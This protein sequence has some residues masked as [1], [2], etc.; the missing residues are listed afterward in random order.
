MARSRKTPRRPG[1]DD[2]RYWQMRETLRRQ[3]RP[4]GV[5]GYPI[6]QQ[7]KWPHPL[8]W[9]CDHIVPRSQLQPND[10]R[11]WH[12]SNARPA[13]LRCNTARGAKPIPGTSGGLNPSGAW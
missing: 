2:K 12:I 8:S 7:L 13:H 6:D 5:C 10:P 1:L 9:S 11:N 3:N 4:C